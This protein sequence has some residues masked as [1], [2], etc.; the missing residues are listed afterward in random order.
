M[1]KLIVLALIMTMLMAGSFIPALRVSATLPTAPP[2]PTV[3][4]LPT[5]SL[6]TP[7]LNTQTPPLPPAPGLPTST[8]LSTGLFYP[9]ATHWV[10][11]PLVSR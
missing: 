4:P 1:K 3:T 9:L 6:P 8:P 2:V 10:F 5:S 7:V 11:C